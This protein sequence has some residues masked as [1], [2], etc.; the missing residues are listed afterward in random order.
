[1]EQ[2]YFGD[3]AGKNVAMSLVLLLAVSSQ[4]IYKDGENFK[5]EETL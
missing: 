3:S 1:M 5:Y 4:K 2:L